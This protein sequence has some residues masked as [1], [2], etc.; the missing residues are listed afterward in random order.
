VRITYDP[1]KREWTLQ[2]RGLDFEDAIEVFAGRVLTGQD[3]QKD[4]G[5]DRYITLGYLRGCVVVVVWTPRGDERRIISMWKA[6]G[7]E[8]KRV[9]KRLGKAGRDDG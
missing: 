7:K 2:E 4:Y 3:T 5:E 6:N 1:A 8:Q 9:R